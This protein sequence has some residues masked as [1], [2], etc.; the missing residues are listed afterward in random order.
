[1][2]VDAGNK[3]NIDIIDIDIQVEFPH[4]AGGVFLSS[5]LGCCTQGIEWEKKQRINFHKFP[6]RIPSNHLFERSSNIISIDSP[7]AR[8]NFWVY[9]FRKRILWELPYYRYQGKKWVKCPYEDL[10]IKGDG[11]WLLNQARFIDQYVS[12][13]P[14][15]IDW[16][17]MLEYPEK[18]WEII[19]QFLESNQKNN[20][21]TLS[22]WL[23]SLND[24]RC[25]LPKKIVINPHHIHWQIWATGIL[26]NQDITSGIDIKNFQDKEYRQWLYSY[27]EKTLEYTEKRTYHTG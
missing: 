18:A 23:E 5:V 12:Q 10:D 17:E 27:I 19:D 16:I 1:M 3:C 24:Y 6:T 20:F 26:Q 22:Q 9:Y 4:G 14:W 2:A 13:Q 7:L 11:F 21:W 8:Y 25:T 15:K